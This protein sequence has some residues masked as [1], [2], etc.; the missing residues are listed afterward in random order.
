M[1]FTHLLLI[2]QDVELR[3]NYIR[4]GLCFK[5]GDIDGDVITCVG[6]CQRSFH[7]KCFKSLFTT[8]PTEDEPVKC[9]ECC[10]GETLCTKCSHPLDEES[11]HC[12]VKNCV[13]RLHKKCADDSIGSSSNRPV[14]PLSN[15]NAGNET[16]S[17]NGFQRGLFF[18]DFDNSRKDIIFEVGIRPK[19]L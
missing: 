17:M 16:H 9:P 7:S 11:V 4:I 13:T 3:C 8:T 2:F 6:S 19:N 5:C 1:P 10:K 14:P 15:E 12:S 18:R